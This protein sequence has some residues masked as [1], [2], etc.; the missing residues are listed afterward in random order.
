MN[1]KKSRHAVSPTKREVRKMED[2][3]KY[4]L[5]AA[6]KY[7]SEIEAMTKGRYL[8]GVE[9]A[10]ASDA[11][12]RCFEIANRLRRLR[13]DN[14]LPQEAWELPVAP[15]RAQ[16]PEITAF[17]VAQTSAL[18]AASNKGKSATE[19]LPEARELLIQASSYLESVKAG[20]LLD[21]ARLG[22]GVTFEAILASTSKDNTVGL[23]LLPGITG[24]VKSA[25][26]ERFKGLVKA[27]RDYY[28]QQDSNEATAE[29]YIKK[30]YLP[31]RV[32]IEI[33]A[34]RFRRKRELALNPRKGWVERPVKKNDP[35]KTGILPKKSE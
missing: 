33:R 24:G 18:L 16:I 5:E 15:K 23:K 26:G 1:A 27:I 9:W 22:G 34:W 13:E 3:L 12:S 10:I 30:K 25:K 28:A 31:T 11:W 32:L 6:K 35:H 19:L 4:E 14:E 21:V 29:R 2:F 20:V 17:E 7:W 8:H